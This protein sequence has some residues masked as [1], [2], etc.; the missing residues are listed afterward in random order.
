MGPLAAAVLLAG[1]ALAEPSL[2]GAWV[3]LD[4]AADQRAVEAGIDRVS[5]EFPLLIRPLVSAY[6][7]RVTRFCPAPGFA[8]AGE[9]LMFSCAGREVFGAVPDGAPFAWISQIRE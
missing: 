7:G 6:L 3:E 5:A 9:R 8:M 1:A 2:L 4:L